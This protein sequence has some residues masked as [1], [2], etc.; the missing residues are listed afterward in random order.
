MSTL[1]I[2]YRPPSSGQLETVLTLARPDDGIILIQDGVFALGSEG[3]RSR[4]AASSKS[5]IRIYALKPD[6]EARSIKS[7][8]YVDV[9]EYDGLIELLERYDRTFS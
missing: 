6:I 7:P 4:L 1:H 5:G 3:E 2:V 8:D 9:R